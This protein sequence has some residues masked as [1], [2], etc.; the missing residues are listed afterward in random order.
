MNDKQAII[1]KILGDAE[2]AAR[3]NLARAEETAREMTERAQA[4]ADRYCAQQADKPA[5]VA[6][7]WK[8]RRATVDR[9]DARKHALSVKKQLID[10]LYA[11]AV[12]TLRNDRREAYLHWIA[13]AIA[14][15][16]DD[17]DEVVVCEADRK[18]VT[19]KFVRSVASDCGKSL[20]LSERVGN[21]AG[22]VTL[23][24]KYCDKNLTVESEL[25]LSR[26][27]CEA[28][29]EQILFGEKG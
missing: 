1:D 25:Q 22:G 6:D 26:D 16:A 19:A 8:T 17:G 27:D 3:D 18:I 12:E 13:R 15:A 14:A 29:L 7:E 10:E 24:G 21:F 28:R 4:E 5:A 11:Q 9:L 23:V 20:T 2:Q